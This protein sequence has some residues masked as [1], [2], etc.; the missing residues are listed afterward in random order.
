MKTQLSLFV[1]AESVA[2]KYTRG[3]NP[4]AGGGF[5]MFK[6]PG[7][8]MILDGQQQE[9]KPNKTP[10]LF[11]I[12]PGTHTLRLED[13]ESNTKRM[14]KKFTA[15]FI[16]A[17]MGL[18]NGSLTQAF[19]FANAASASSFNKVYEDGTMEFTIGDGD[20]LKLNCQATAKGVV[21]ILPAD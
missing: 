13:P 11:D 15:G 9:L 7:V 20:I 4:F 14:G 12:T 18:A 21:K 6:N 16:S 19:V 2:A 1:K 8:L 10:Y 3:M 17:T 5:A